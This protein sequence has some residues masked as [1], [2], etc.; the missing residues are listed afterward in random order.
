MLSRNLVRWYTITI[1]DLFLHETQ[2]RTT[3][4]YIL[5]S[6]FLQAIILISNILFISTVHRLVSIQFYDHDK[7]K[8]WQVK[9]FFLSGELF[10]LVLKI[11]ALYYLGSLLANQILWLGISNTNTIE[12]VMTRRDSFEKAFFALQFVLGFVILVGAVVLTFLIQGDP[13][14]SYFAEI[15]KLFLLIQYFPSPLVQ[16]EGYPAR[17]GCVPLGSNNH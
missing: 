2:L 11:M 7:L 4:G 5:L 8:R 14:V 6:F 15:W 10:V 13:A 1:I 12:G 16:S 17:S 9:S 3:Y